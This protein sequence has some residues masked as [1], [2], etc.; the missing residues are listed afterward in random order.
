M[1]KLFLSF[2]LLFTLISCN[3][4]NNDNIEK[5]VGRVFYNV[6]EYFNETNYYIIFDT[7]RGILPIYFDPMGIS[8][9]R[10][11]A[12]AFITN[13]SNNY[14]Y[15]SSIT[16]LNHI[17]FNAIKFDKDKMYVH[18]IND[19]NSSDEFW[20][21]ITYEQLIDNFYYSNTYTLAKEGSEEEKYILD[22]INNSLSGNE[23]DDNYIS[24]KYYNYNYDNN[25]DGIYVEAFNKILGL[26]N[27]QYKNND[28]EK[29]EKNTSNEFLEKYKNDFYNI[30]YM[31]KDSE[32]YFLIEFDMRDYDTNLKVSVVNEIE[33]LIE[34]GEY[35]LYQPIDR[36]KIG[37]FLSWKIISKYAFEK[38][39]NKFI[40]GLN[41]RTI[42]MSMFIDL[43]GFSTDDK[44]NFYTEDGKLLYE[45]QTVINEYRGIYR[46]YSE[47]DTNDK[48][49]FTSIDIKNGSYNIS[50][51]KS[52]GT[53]Y[54]VDWFSDDI[55]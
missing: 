11:A 21:D 31:Y 16:S 10:I 55:F 54:S 30:T 12:Y 36:S 4:Q 9:K 25:K 13:T 49:I 15:Y 18:T 19:Y 24:I 28:R 29:I 39:S 33:N 43:T 37:R 53:M 1:N 2:I 41:S 7:D 8:Y 35:I 34:E 44:G 6:D 20:Y 14:Y 47:T 46:V 40:R 51:K 27:N 52:Y 23:N 42:T 17:K 48:Y 45:L 22:I 26:N 5:Y 32:D 50:E 3:A 38:M